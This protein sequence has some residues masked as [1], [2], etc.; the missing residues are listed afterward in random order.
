M[1]HQGMRHTSFLLQ[2]KGSKIDIKSTMRLFKD[3]I[4]SW[5]DT[6]CTVKIFEGPIISRSCTQNHI[7]CFSSYYNYFH[8]ILR[9]FDVLPNFPFT[10]SETKSDY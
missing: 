7:I 3:L 5:I 8:S 4:F 2:L 10:T 1:I 9:L 6:K